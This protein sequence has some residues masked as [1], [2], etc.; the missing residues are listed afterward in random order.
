MAVAVLGGILVC[1][2]P[3]LPWWSQR[4]GMIELHEQI[5][6]VTSWPGMVCELSGAALLGLCAYMISKPAAKLSVSV[7][8]AGSLSF[9]VSLGALLAGKT[10]LG[11]TVELTP[12]VGLYLIVVG[13][14]AGTV[15]G[16]M[17]KRK[18]S[19]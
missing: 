5:I 12:Q 8:A 13:G 18:D 16:Y 2:A 10:L 9:V 7:L 3:L 1:F 6:G 14:A 4:I 15:G 11:T 19:R 17:L